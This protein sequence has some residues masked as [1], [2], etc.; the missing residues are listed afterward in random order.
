MP[1]YRI[2]ESRPDWYGG[3][4]PIYQIHDESGPIRELKWDVEQQAIDALESLN[5]DHA[6][7]ADIRY[8]LNGKPH[9]SEAPAHFSENEDVVYL[10]EEENLP[11]VD[12][13]LTTTEEKRAA[14]IKNGYSEIVVFWESIPPFE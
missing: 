10:F 2:E 1:K 8:N 12:R 4:G 14:L 3:L 11:D 9:Q 13:G 7:L 5:N 6:L